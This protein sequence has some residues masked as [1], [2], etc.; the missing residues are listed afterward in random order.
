MV[1]KNLKLTHR[2]LALQESHK[3]YSQELSELENN[4]RQTMQAANVNLN[5][6]KNKTSDVN[7]MSFFKT[8]N[9]KDIHDLFEKASQLKIIFDSII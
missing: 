6:D 2:V 4:A 5:I 3:K 9:E 8:P 1:S 7:L